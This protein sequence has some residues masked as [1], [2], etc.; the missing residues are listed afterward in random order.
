VCE[1]LG[2]DLVFAPRPGDVSGAARLHGARRPHAEHLCGAFRPGH[3]DGV[4]TVVLKLFNIVQP[5]VAYFGEKDA[6]QLAIIRRMVRPERAGDDHRRA[7]GAGAD[8]L[9][10]S[11]RNQHLERRGARA[12]APALSGA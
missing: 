3:F 10:L 4:A 7:H 6:Q 5:D 9:A 2:V 11:S 8:G 12:R 1:R